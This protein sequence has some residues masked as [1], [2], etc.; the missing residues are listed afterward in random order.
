MDITTSETIEIQVDSKP[1]YR[2][3]RDTSGLITVTD[4]N[5][6]SNGTVFFEDRD[7]LETF[8]FALK[9]IQRY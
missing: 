5:S 6:A 4:L 7:V 2:L 9:R 1:A 3:R 8:A